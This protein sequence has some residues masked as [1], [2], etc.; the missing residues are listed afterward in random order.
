[1]V[2]ERNMELASLTIHFSLL[3]FFAIFLMYWM[4]MQRPIYTRQS[5]LMVT[6][7]ATYK[8]GR[9]YDDDFCVEERRK[10]RRELLYYLACPLLLSLTAG[11]VLTGPYI[12]HWVYSSGESPYTA[13][14][15]NKYL[16]LPC[17]YPFPTHEGVLHLVVVVL[18]LA[19]VF[20]VAL[21][22]V[23]ILVMLIFNTQRIRYEMRVVG[24]SLKTLF[25]RAEKMFLEQNPHR[26]REKLRDDPGYQKMIGVCLKDT[27]I[28]HHA[29][30]EILSL[31]TKQAD[32][33]AALA[34]T[35]GTGVIAMCLFNILMARRDENY[36]SI[37]LFSMLVFVETL[38][39]FVMSLCG[40]SITSESVNLRHEL[41]FTK[42][43]NLDIENR[44][45]LLNIQ[46]NLVEPVIVS[47]LGLI[48]LNMN[49]FSSIINTAYSFFN[50]MN[51]QME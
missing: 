39:M 24:Y 9:I 25:H 28:H 14:M 26:K 30:S 46:T 2:M 15:V 47:A 48:E 20:S 16:P 5:L 49:S 19:A 38:V 44:K 23:T 45:T 8:S 4:N 3:I 34:Y 11:Y 51:T 10:N 35:I 17:W 1:M 36:T 50:L 37:V 6:D 43:Y 22:L 42:W 7:V 40:E 33:P 18:Q 29:V 27:I 13:N 31:F 12:R 21:I 41:Y 32:M